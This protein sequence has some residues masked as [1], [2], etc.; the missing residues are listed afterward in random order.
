VRTLLL[1]VV[2]TGGVI[3]WVAYQARVQREAVAAIQ[4]V[5][6]RAM[7]EMPRS[8]RLPPAPPKSP[9]KLWV[10][11][12][13]GDDAIDSVKFVGM[14][15]DRVDDPLMKKIGTL[16][17]LEYLGFM[18]RA[19]PQSLTQEGISELHRLT[20]LRDFSANRGPGVDGPVDVTPLLAGIGNQR[21]L[22]RLG[23]ANAHP[24]DEDLARIGALVELEELRLDG[25]AIT[26]AGFAHLSSLTK[27]NRL[28]LNRCSVTDL[29]PLA[30]MRSLAFLDFGRSAPPVAMSQPREVVSL[31][32]LRGKTR[33]FQVNLSSHVTD[34]ENIKVLASLP[35]LSEFQIGGRRITEA[36]L[37]ILSTRPRLDFLALRNTSIQSLHPLGAQV[38][39][40][41]RLELSGSPISD[42]GL[43]P[44][45]SAATL[46]LLDLSNTEVTDAGLAIIG[47]LP[48]LR[49]LLLNGTQITG[50]GLASLTKSPMLMMLQLRGVE[51]SEQGLSQ[52]SSIKRLG[53]L[54]L[55][56]TALDDQKMSMIARARSLI[57]LDLSRTKISDKGI[58]ELKPL[59]KLQR[60]IVDRC[61]ITDN[62]IGYF[63]A[64][65][66][67]NSIS[68][69]DTNVT[70]AGIEQLAN[71]PSLESVRIHGGRITPTGMMRLKQLKPTLQIDATS[72]S[73]DE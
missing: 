18:V 71:L 49:G 19:F 13:L 32:P 20:A 31:A 1:L 4:R 46:M 22:Q 70:D 69:I 53:H 28:Y 35:A 23:L 38:T 33:L 60:L 3:G 58:A 41:Q 61:S 55:A 66:K 42:K 62:A 25:R 64:F 52:L 34:D 2:A 50:D 24:R 6:G 47:E 72:P 21:H 51:L 37:A 48:A 67:L 44:L 16:R 7:Y 40:L 30:S 39:K 63:G 29:S 59:R 14:S 17:Q 12:L 10:R 27:I 5:G 68:L 43:R 57:F 15:L 9:T 11:K 26:N 56:N 73:E 65:P 36:A 54:S 8:R 45:S